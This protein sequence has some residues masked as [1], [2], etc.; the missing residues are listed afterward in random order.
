MYSKK[1][2]DTW[3]WIKIETGLIHPVSS[4]QHLSARRALSAVLNH[5]M[6]EIDDVA[7]SRE[8][9]KARELR[10]SQWWKRQ[11]AR[12]WCHYCGRSF[13]P[14][15]LTMDHIVPIARGGKSTKGN[16][17]PA[18][19]A[20]NNKKKYMLPIEWE[21]YLQSLSENGVGWHQ[22]SGCCP[23]SFP[24]KFWEAA[25]GIFFEVMSLIWP[26]RSQHGTMLDVPPWPSYNRLVS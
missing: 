14:E 22:L 2:L 25:R 23:N 16:V 5:F 9:Q 8:R 24:I 1:I 15:A 6:T 7:L 12:G 3:C 11:L 20:C 21:E 4:N 10:G 26:D 18:C 13:S 17:V 19:K